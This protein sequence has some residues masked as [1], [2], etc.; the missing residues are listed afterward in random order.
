M[1]KAGVVVVLPHP[2]YSGIQVN[3]M[4]ISIALVYIISY[5]YNC[6]EGYHSALSFRACKLD[7]SRDSLKEETACLYAAR[8]SKFVKNPSH[9]RMDIDLTILMVIS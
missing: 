3:F 2:D 4:Y 8:A 9:R 5:F 6:L 1:G 7:L